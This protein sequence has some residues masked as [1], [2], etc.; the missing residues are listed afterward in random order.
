MIPVLCLLISA[1]ALFVCPCAFVVVFN[2]RQPSNPLRIVFAAIVVV[3][4]VA[5][6]WTTFRYSYYVNSNTK[7]CGWPIPIVVF[8]RDGPNAPWLDF[9]G[10]T[11]LGAYPVNFSLFLFIPSTVFVNLARR[12][13]IQRLTETP[14]PNGYIK[15]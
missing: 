11:V 1:A 12:F 8:Q 10:W 14:H 4:G 15:T 7:V 6:F 3:I 5:A 9:I 13:R 2:R